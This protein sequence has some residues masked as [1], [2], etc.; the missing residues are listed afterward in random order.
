VLTGVAAANFTAYT[1]MK[2]FALKYQNLPELPSYQAM[3]LGRASDL[4]VLSQTNARK[5]IS[6][7]MGPFSN[8]PSL[9]LLPSLHGR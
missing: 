4:S 2:K 7:A 8:A 5:V 3:V 6:G 9:S 1:E